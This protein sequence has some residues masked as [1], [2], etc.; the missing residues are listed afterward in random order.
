MWNF[1]PKKNTLLN[2]ASTGKDLRHS[3]HF[4]RV[5]LSNTVEPF[6]DVFFPASS[7]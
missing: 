3:V 5:Y 2:P 6:R 7:V 4:R 1:F